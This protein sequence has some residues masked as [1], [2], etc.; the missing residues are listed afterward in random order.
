MKKFLPALLLIPCS[1]FLTPDSAQNIST[2]AGNGFG[3]FSG[4]G[5]QATAAE[6][7][8]PCGIGTDASGNVYIADETGNRVR[9]V[10]T[11]G[12]ITTV[13][14][15][16][17]GGFSGDGG[18]ATAAEISSPQGLTVDRKGNIYI[19]DF[20]NNRIRKVNTN[21]VI[22]TFA[23]IG[24]NAFSGDGGP[25]TA[26]ELNAPSEVA[27]DTMGN[28]YIADET[29]NRIRKI[30]TSGIIS[31][32]AG[33]G[34]GGFSGDGGQATAAEIN[35]I[36][37]VS[38]DNSNNVYI[39]DY[40]NN[41]IRKVGTTGIITTIAGNGT[42]GFG[43]DGSAATAA[44]L[45]GPCTVHVGST[46]LIYIADGMNYRIRMINTS[47]VI[48]TIA[49][50][51]ISGFGGDGGPATAAMFNYPFGVAVDL[52][53]NVYVG[54]VFNN[55]VREI[56]AMPLITYEMKADNEVKV[57]P[58][59][60]NGKFTIQESGARNQNSVVEIYNML[61][62][63]VFSKSLLHLTTEY[64]LDLSSQSAGIYLYRILT[65]IGNLAA[66]GKL[67]IQK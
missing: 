4:D 56:A 31:T 51:G 40:S 58:N 12:I 15:T 6:I 63:K 39:A 32:Y 30:N 62:E 53:G 18:P 11:A 34:F 17:T 44:M 13:A 3:G 47:G 42:A 33:N 23:G 8:N 67:I 27:A 46:G 50:D 21:A 57:F 48:T 22:S 65:E 7:Y 64:S 14:G 1:L 54:D 45:N 26:A 61:G 37:G 5:G 36:T 29:N 16:I 55:R 35:N 25:A 41:R 9:K 49:G 59:P 20:A 60:N 43:G 28:I 19:A 24:T 66:E 2:I 10:T 38:T 52:S